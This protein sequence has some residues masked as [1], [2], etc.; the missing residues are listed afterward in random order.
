MLPETALVVYC[1]RM[2]RSP[3]FKYHVP[4]TG[5]WCSMLRRCGGFT[6]V[7]RAMGFEVEPRNA[8]SQRGEGPPPLSL[9]SHCV[10]AGSGLN[11]P[12]DQRPPLPAS[13]DPNDLGPSGGIV[14]PQLVISP[15]NQEVWQSFKSPNRSHPCLQSNGPFMHGEQIM[16]VSAAGLSRSSILT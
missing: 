6:R 7:E 4:L 9:H 11:S 12:G 8:H 2:M 10:M 16:Q 13:L 3:P 14:R 15:T 1:P 5:A